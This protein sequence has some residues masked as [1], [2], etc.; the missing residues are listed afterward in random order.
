MFDIYILVEHNPTNISK[1]SHL[2]SPSRRHF[3]LILVSRVKNVSGGD[4]LEKRSIFEG[5][6][7]YIPHP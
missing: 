5:F 7:L 4:F 6:Y 2:N 3:I 1:K